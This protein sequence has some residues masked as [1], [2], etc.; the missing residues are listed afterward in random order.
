[1]SVYECVWCCVCGCLTPTHPSTYPSTFTH[2]HTHTYSPSYS[3]HTCPTPTTSHHTHTTNAHAE[4]G[5][6]SGARVLAL[7]PAPSLDAVFRFHKPTTA[8][9]M[10]AITQGGTTGEYKL[11]TK[12]DALLEPSAPSGDRKVCVYVWGC[13]GVFLGVCVFVCTHRCVSVCTCLPLPTKP[14]TI[15]LQHK[16][17]HDIPPAHHHHHHSHGTFAM[18]AHG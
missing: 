15:F 14:T 1:M 6:P 3:S 4:M 12:A 9:H 2:I 7:P 18:H 5:G 16:T 11:I 13:V 8:R 10:A 17:H